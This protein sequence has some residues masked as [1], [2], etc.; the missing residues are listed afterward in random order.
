LYVQGD[1]AVAISS[2]K[3]QSLLEKG[4]PEATFLGKVTKESGETLTLK[5]EQ[6]GSPTGGANMTRKY[7][8]SKGS[9]VVTHINSGSGKIFGTT[10]TAESL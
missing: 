4:E 5:K 10:T 7:L 2:S 9:K 1:K 8:G 3:L 6:S